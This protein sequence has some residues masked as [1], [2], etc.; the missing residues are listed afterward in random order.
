MGGITYNV[1]YKLSITRVVQTAAQKSSLQTPDRTFASRVKKQH[2]YCSDGGGGKQA[3]NEMAEIN[4]P[5]PR[6]RAAYARLGQRLDDVWI[7]RI[8]TPPQPDAPFAFFDSF[9]VAGAVSCAFARSTR[10]L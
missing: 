9:S 8:S 5:G 7:D 2:Y 1:V 4:Q 3:Y 10:Y 6:L